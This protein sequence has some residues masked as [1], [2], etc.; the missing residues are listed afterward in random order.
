M[1]Q[2]KLPYANNLIIPITDLIEYYQ[3]NKLNYLIIGS[4]QVTLQNHPKPDSFDV[5]IRTH[6]SVVKYK[7]TCQSVDNVISQIIKHK[8][9]S[10][11]LRKCPKTNRICKALVFCDNQK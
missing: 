2:I 1:E 10:L 7:D 4:T 8:S 9:F 11:G 6:P 5:W 3:N